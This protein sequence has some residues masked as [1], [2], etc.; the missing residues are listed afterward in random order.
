MTKD[1]RYTNAYNYFVTLFAVLYSTLCF[2]GFGLGLL[3]KD[4]IIMNYLLIR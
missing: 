3:V 4:M 1:Q 2:D